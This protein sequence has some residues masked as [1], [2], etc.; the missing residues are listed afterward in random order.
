MDDFFSCSGVGEDE[1]L[2]CNSEDKKIL[3]SGHKEEQINN[4]NLIFM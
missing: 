3:T 4:N 1:C 2:I